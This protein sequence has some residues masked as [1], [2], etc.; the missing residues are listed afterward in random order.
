MEQLERKWWG[1]S[2]SCC[3]KII[4]RNKQFCQTNSFSR[5][6]VIWKLNNFAER[7]EQIAKL[8]ESLIQSDIGNEHQNSNRDGRGAGTQGTKNFTSAVKR[9]PFSGLNCA[10]CQDLC[11]LFCEQIVV[12]SVNTRAL[13]GVTCNGIIFVWPR[14]RRSFLFSSIFHLRHSFIFSCSPHI[15]TRA[16][17][18]RYPSVRQSC[19]SS[20]VEKLYGVPSFPTENFTQSQFS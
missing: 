15:M 8:C 7:W 20:S 10:F 4:N 9:W 5:V 17:L 6:L 1:P 2:L 16:C 3:F 19:S 13:T 18:R 14:K 11:W 12:N